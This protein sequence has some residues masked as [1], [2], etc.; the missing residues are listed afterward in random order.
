MAKIECSNWIKCIIFRINKEHMWLMI[1]NKSLKKVWMCDTNICFEIETE[2]CY[3]YHCQAQPSHS[4]SWSCAVLSLISG[5]FSQLS[6]IVEGWSQSHS[7]WPHWKTNWME[8]NLSGRQPQWKMTSIEDD[9]NGRW[10]QWKMTS[11]DDDLNGGLTQLKTTS[12][13]SNV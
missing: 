7:C 1:I 10:P 11:V 3:C 4:S 9:L 12:I 5:L 13:Y 2:S 8:D 6:C